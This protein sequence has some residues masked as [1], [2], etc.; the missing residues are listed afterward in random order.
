MTLVRD[1]IE[2]WE[3]DVDFSTYDD[4]ISASPQQVHKQK[5]E[6]REAVQTLIND[7]VNSISN[8]CDC[9]QKNQQPQTA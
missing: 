3:S 2:D 7:A 4:S 9:Q 8:E 6:H 1:Q 5:A